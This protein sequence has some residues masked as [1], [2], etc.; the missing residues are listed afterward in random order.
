MRTTASFVLALFITLISS[1]R[2][3]QLVDRVTRIGLSGYVVDTN[4]GKP[5]P[6]AKIWVQYQFMASG[7]AMRFPGEAVTDVKGYFDIPSEYKKSKYLYE[8]TN[9]PSNPDGWRPDVPVKIMIQHPGYKRFFL[10]FPTKRQ[11]R[12]VPRLRQ[13]YPIFKQG[14]TYRIEPRVVEPVR[15]ANPPTPAAAEGGSR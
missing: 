12:K 14:E 15:R 9:D 1:G 11:N 5:V 7:L 3:D 6:N 10:E 2:G 4:S 8:V 13:T